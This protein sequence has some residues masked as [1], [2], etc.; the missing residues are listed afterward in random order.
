MNS[1]GRL[2]TVDYD[3]LDRP[4][5]VTYPDGTYKETVY[6]R[7]DAEKHRDRLGRWAETFHDALRR[8]VATRDPAGR[9][10]TQQWCTCGSL[11][12]V[13]D[14][15]NNATAWARDAQGRITNESRNGITTRLFNYEST[16]SRLHQTTDAKGQFTTYQYALDDSLQQISYSNTPTPNPNVSLAYESSYRR[17]SSMQDGTGTT[18][19]AYYPVTQPPSIGAGRLSSIDGPLS[20]DTLTYGYDELGRLV[21]AAMN[22]VSVS[23]SYD[24]LGRLTSESGPLG[25]FGYSYVGATGRISQLAYPN[26]Q[27]SQY[28]YVSAPADPRLQEI[29]HL[30]A[31]AVNLSQ[32]DYTYDVAGRIRAWTQQTAADPANV[33]EFDY[34]AADQLSAATLKTTDPTPTIL[35]RYGYAYDSA[36]NRTSE[37]VDNGVLSSSYDGRNELTSRQAGGMLLFR[38][39]VNEAAT[40]TVQGT[41][42]AVT[43]D[44]RFVGAAS[45]TSGTN[46]VAVAAT[47]P[48][49]NLRANTYQVAVSGTGATYSYDQNGNLTSDGTRGFEWDAEDRLTAITRGSRRTEFTYDGRGRRVEILQKDGGSVISDR[50]YVWCGEELCEERDSSGATTLKRFYRHGMADNGVP[51]Y[52]TR[53]HLGSLR[54]MTDAT[55]SLRARYDYDPFGRATKLAGDRDA[56]I[57]FAGQPVD[58]SGASDPE[59]GLLYNRA[60]FYDPDTARFLGEDPLGLGGGWNLYGYALNNP[61]NWVDPLGLGAVPPKPPSLPPPV[62]CLPGSSGNGSGCIPIEPPPPATP[63]PTACIGPPGSPSCAPKCHHDHDLFMLCLS[64]GGYVDA[65]GA[66]AESGASMMVTGCFATISL[67]LKDC[68]EKAE[69]CAPPGGGEPPVPPDLEAN[70]PHVHPP[71]EFVPP[72]NTKPPRNSGGPPRFPRGPR[73]R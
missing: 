7:L 28:T 23:Y 54:E 6:N 34:D 66:S 59:Y 37:Q 35:K 18:T 38:G 16:T 9:T 56:P 57:G 32:F 65:S 5:R 43:A 64:M 15:N 50:R 72:P 25:P 44:N 33:Y 17:L 45:M 26:G 40:V 63:S 14:G 46:T 47:D 48:S 27:V 53:D 70:S 39:T 13:I 62:L 61:V 51:Y 11:E 21:S 31:G 58:V 71:G 1:E 67:Q 29:K 42:A 4:L 22:G 52:Y 41:A 68:W 10:T 69:M 8:V 12:K 49:G 20:A 3:S 24:N 55:G 36:G 73:G 2:L 60:R 19:Y 30:T